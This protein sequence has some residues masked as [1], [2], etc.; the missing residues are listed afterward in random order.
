MSYAYLVI[1]IMS[2]AYLVSRIMSLVRPQG[3]P[4]ES[5]RGVPTDRFGWEGDDDSSVKEHRGTS[6]RHWGRGNF[7]M[8]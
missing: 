6:P 8:G 7:T 5:N 2:H 4:R 3:E 1:S